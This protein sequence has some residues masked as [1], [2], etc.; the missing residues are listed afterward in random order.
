P[1]TT[2]SPFGATT[3][4]T[5]YDGTPSTVTTTVNGRW[6]KVT[7]DGL[8]RPIKTEAGD[9]SG[10]VSVAETEYD[11]Y[12][13]APA[14]KLKRTALPHAPG[15]TPVWTTYTYDGIGRT[16]T[17]STVGTDTQTTTTYA[18]QGNTVTVTDA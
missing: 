5:Y 14:G 15:A 3:T 10:T 11:S 9:G 8:G 2:T 6:T 18:Y 13:C 7:K 16:L 4:N 17:T 12:G 1:G